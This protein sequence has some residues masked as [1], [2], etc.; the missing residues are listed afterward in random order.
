MGIGK[1]Y[2]AHQGLGG[3]TGTGTGTGKSGLEERRGWDEQP[4][5]QLCPWRGKYGAVGQSQAWEG[6]QTFSRAPRQSYWKSHVKRAR[7]ERA[8]GT[9]NS[10]VSMVGPYQYCA[11]V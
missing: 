11:C 1:K 2:K 5:E 10:Q 3:W 9:I 4:D 6:K 8:V 7:R